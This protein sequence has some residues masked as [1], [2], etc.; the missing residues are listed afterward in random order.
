[1]ACSYQNLKA[2]AVTTG[3]VGRHHVVIKLASR[4]LTRRS[5]GGTA[6]SVTLCQRSREMSALILIVGKDLCVSHVE[7]ALADL[8]LGNYMCVD[9]PETAD[10]LMRDGY[11]CGVLIVDRAVFGSAGA[12]NDWIA[13]NPQAVPI[14]TDKC[15][16]W[17]ATFLGQVKDAVELSRH[18]ATETSQKG[19]H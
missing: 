12:R 1:M 15:Q 10:W 5:Y 6:Y 9:D 14:V 13:A 3:N 16:T 8:T 2:W 11:S 19:I 4:S 17:S 7:T 18:L